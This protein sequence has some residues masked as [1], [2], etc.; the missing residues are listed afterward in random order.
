MAKDKMNEDQRDMVN[1]LRDDGFIVIIW[2][3]A[4]LEG[5]D[6]EDTEYLEEVVIQKGNDFIDFAH[7]CQAEPA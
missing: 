4:E 2:T 7:E 6:A 3:P 5:L 1:S